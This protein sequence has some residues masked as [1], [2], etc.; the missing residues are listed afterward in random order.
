VT[1]LVLI[2]GLQGRWE[3]MKRAVDALVRSFRVVTLSLADELLAGARFDSSRGMDSYVDQIERTLDQLGLTRAAVCGVSL[4]GLIALRFA[5]ERPERTSALILVS[6]PGPHWTISPHQRLFARFPRLSA[7]LFFAGLPGR[8]RAEL[9]CALPDGRERR[10]LAWEQARTLVRAPLSPSRMA[11][12]ALVIGTANTV[13]DCARVN[14]PTLIVTGEPRLDRV[15]P[16]EGVEGTSEYARI[17]AGARLV[18]L[19]RTGHL[20][21]ITRPQEFAAVLADFVHT[22]RQIPARPVEELGGPDRGLPGSTEDA[23]H[24]AA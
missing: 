24:H 12:R 14:V 17:I 18:Q 20:G 5:A 22:A 15:V 2:P 8:L 1:D 21:C 23:G 9:V 11:A 16:V 6:T 19:D 13:S 10:K 4:G 7:P 3:Y